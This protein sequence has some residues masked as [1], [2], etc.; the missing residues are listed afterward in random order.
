MNIYTKT[1]DDG[2][3]SLVGG[4]RVSKTDLRL[5][6]YGTIDELSAHLGLLLCHITDEK[7]K[8]DILWIQ[9]RLFSAGGQLA[10]DTESTKLPESCMISAEHVSQIETMIDS[11]DSALPRH[12]RFILPGGCIASAEAG[13]ARTVCRR[14]ERCILKLDGSAAP[15]CHLKE[16]INRLS[17]YLFVLS[18]KLNKD[19]NTP[20]IFW[21][22]R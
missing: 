8:N 22:N 13:V 10:T 11:I 21:E 7:D 16:F 20:E 9:H 5:E 3:T 2:T 12:D 15:D 17:D 6:A 19:S 4:K 1:G 18:R 14:A